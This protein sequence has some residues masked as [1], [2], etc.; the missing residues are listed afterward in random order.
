MPSNPGPLAGFRV[1]D[2][3]TMI[4]GPMATGLLGDQGADVIKIE[5]PGV[6]DLMRLLGKPRGGITAS[7]ATT[8]RNKR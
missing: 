7:F 2:L 4:S 5:C 3:T 8:N 1:L 6:G